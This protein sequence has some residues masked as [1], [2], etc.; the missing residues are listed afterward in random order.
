MTEVVDRSAGKPPVRKVAVPSMSFSQHAPLV[1]L[2][3]ADYPDAK[4]NT[5]NENHYHS[6]AATIDYLRGYE[7]AIVSFERITDAVLAALS[8]CVPE[9]VYNEAAIESWKSRFAGHS[10]LSTRAMRG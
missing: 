9:R 7:A 5:A 6:E 1:D 3:R 4:I 2:L 8:G 10:L